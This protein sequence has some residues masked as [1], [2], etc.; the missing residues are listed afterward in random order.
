VS[1]RFNLRHTVLARCVKGLKHYNTA[2]GMSRAGSVVWPLVLFWTLAGG[3]GPLRAAGQITSY[4]LLEGSDLTDDCLVCD[5]VTAPVPLRG[6]FQLLPLDSNPLFTRYQLTNIVFRITGTAGLTYEVVGSG[7]Y[8]VGGE[9]A[10]LQDLSLTVQINDGFTNSLC[11]FTNA[12]AQVKSPWPEIQTEADQSNGTFLRLYRLKLN[13]APAPQFRSVSIVSGTG[14]IRLEWQ[15]FGSAVQLE[16]SVA[17]EGPYAAI[18]TNLTEQAFEDVG[19]LT[20]AA[21]YFYRLR[22]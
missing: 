14:T 12:Q 17:V 2:S 10:L 1:G 5:R 8:Q 6:A 16:R 11:L 19:V 4:A 20:K 3:L 9:V 21:Q 7:I 15:S 22:E 13:A 18:A